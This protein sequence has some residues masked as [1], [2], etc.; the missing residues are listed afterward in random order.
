[1]QS[2]LP[3]TPTFIKL[4]KRK[5]FVAEFEKVKDAFIPI[6]HLRVKDQTQH[7]NLMLV[8]SIFPEIL[9]Y[10]GQIASR[11]GKLKL[12][13]L[14]DELVQ[15][16]HFHREYASLFYKRKFYDFV[17]LLL[18]SNMNGRAVCQGKLDYSRIY[19]FKDANG[20]LQFLNCYEQNVLIE[21]AIENCIC[22]VQSK[23]SSRGSRKLYFTLQMPSELCLT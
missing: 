6:V 9:G 18:Y 19:C 22:T 11:N 1:M 10:A 16:N 5:L 13:Q 3:T 7:L 12:Q 20:Q 23:A 8:D 15:V 14:V 21:L 4:A 2:S 17:Q